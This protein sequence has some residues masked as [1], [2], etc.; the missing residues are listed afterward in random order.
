MAG[1]GA[2]QQDPVGRRLQHCGRHL[3]GYPAHPP[4]RGRGPG[5]K[6]GPRRSR[7]GACLA[8]RPANPPRQRPG[9]VPHPSPAPV[10]EVISCF[11]FPMPTGKVA[12]NLW[13]AGLAMAWKLMV[14]LFLVVSLTGSTPE[15]EPAPQTIDETVAL[16]LSADE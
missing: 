5:R 16:G 10:E 7:R 11:R 6:G 15:K 2:V 8:D 1:R 3:R 13:S 12:D 14:A 4:L 9:A